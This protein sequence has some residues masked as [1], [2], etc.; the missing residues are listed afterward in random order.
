[1]INQPTV[2]RKTTVGVV[3][4]FMETASKLIEE[5]AKFIGGQKELADALGVS[6]QAVA[7]WKKSRIPAERVLDIER[8]T[9]IS[10]SRLRPDLYP[11]ESAA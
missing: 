1:M 8:V 4:R 2:D 10:K 7:K 9:T 3:S 11:A 6:P 5:A